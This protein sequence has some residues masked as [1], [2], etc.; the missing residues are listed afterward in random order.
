MRR[1]VAAGSFSFALATASCAALLG[2]D[3]LE[4][5][6]LTPDG[7]SLADTGADGNVGPDPLCGSLGVPDPPAGPGGGAMEV[8]GALRTLD[9]GISLDGGVSSVPGFN[10]DRTCS[11]TI[12]TSS[13]TV[14][15][16][17]SSFEGRIADKPVGIDNSAYG[18]LAL[19]SGVSTTFNTDS[20]SQGVTSG[21]YG[22]TFRVR[23]WNGG[24]NDSDLEVE[25][26]PALG[27]EGGLPDG[28]LA[29]D[30]TDR[31]LIDQRFRLAVDVDGSSIRSETA[32]LRDGQLVARFKKVTIQ[33]LLGDDVKPFE[34]TLD[35]AVLTGQLEGE[36]GAF[37]AGGLLGGRWS[38]ARFL[39][40]VRQI[41]VRNG[42]GIIRSTVCEGGDAGR[43]LFGT[44]QSF[45]C[46]VRD[47]RG[48]SQ[49]NRGLPCD[50]VS[51]AAR[52]EGYRTGIGAWT[53][54][55]ETPTRCTDAGD[56]PA[57]SCP[58]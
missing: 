19:I 3:R 32:Y 25:V 18:L 56:F 23:G 55:A 52:I 37:L 49:D 42:N 44:V 39:D 6:S 31:W 28:G 2:F 5:G 43:V 58:D 14:A 11:P 36:G 50:A 53:T 16:T 46:D 54:F 34:I 41:Y 40:Q 35:D 47:L 20:I 15:I 1:L 4:E 9:F 26:F 33:A 22:A 8:T 7:A 38:A 17:A 51:A 24:P 10:L 30:T 27:S 13:C 45:T 57:A 12:E 48:D 29:Y 21:L